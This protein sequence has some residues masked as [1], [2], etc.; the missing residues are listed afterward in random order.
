MKVKNV[1]IRAYYKLGGD[2]IT[3]PENPHHGR[4]FNNVNVEFS[5]KPMIIGGVKFEWDV[6]KI[7]GYEY[8]ECELVDVVHL[9]DDTLIIKICE[10]W[11]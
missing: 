5:T 6:V 1:V 10:D 7:E 11:G 8:I 2:Y 3:F 9:P 4:E